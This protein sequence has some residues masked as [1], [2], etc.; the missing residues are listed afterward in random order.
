MTDVPDEIGELVSLRELIL[1]ANELTRLPKT[2]ERLIALEL[3]DLTDNYDLE[4]E[5]PASMQVRAD[6]GDLIVKLG[7]AEDEPGIK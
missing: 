1:S 5:I 7:E 6:A 3:L 4:W 2:M